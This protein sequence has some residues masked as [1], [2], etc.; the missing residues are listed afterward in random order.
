MLVGFTRYSRN[1]SF[2]VLG[3]NR[4]FLLVMAA[5]SIAG[6]FIGGLLLGVVL[7]AVLLPALAAILLI[8]AVKVWG[9]RN[10]NRLC[11]GVYARGVLAECIEIDC[12][13]RP[14]CR[15]AE[16]H[17]TTDRSLPSVQVGPGHSSRI[18]GVAGSIP[19]ENA[20]APR[21]FRRRAPAPCR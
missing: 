9:T 2:S 19:K 14:F 1:R 4:T 21:R 17:R 12:T 7:D 18:D 15:H 16:T 11:S 6:A 20:D 5:G 10:P 8:S 3:R 13:A